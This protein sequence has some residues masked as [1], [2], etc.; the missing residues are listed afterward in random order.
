MAA[1]LTKGDGG[2]RMAWIGIASAVMVAGCQQAQE[3]PAAPQPKVASGPAPILASDLMMRY[4]GQELTFDWASSPEVSLERGLYTAIRKDA[5]DAFQSAL[6]EARQGQVEAGKAGYPFNAYSYDQRWTYEAE[7]PQL[8]VLSSVTSSYT[9]GA[10]GMQSYA[11]GIWDRVGGTR[12]GSWDLFANRDAAAKALT[13][14]WCG[15]LNAER[16]RRREGQ[17]LGVFEDCPPITEQTLVPVGSPKIMRFKLIAAPYVAGPY[18][19]GTYEIWIDPTPAT[20]YIAD[21]YKPSF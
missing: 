13:P 3:K 10:H 19:E 4:R 1:R 11:V 2:M 20:P 14:E 21:A 7:T 16:K 17:A 15:E 12:I 9:G 6:A 5:D 8:L 18:A